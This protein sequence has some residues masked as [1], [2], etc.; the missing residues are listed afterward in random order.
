MDLLSRTVC[1]LAQMYVQN[2]WARANNLLIQVGL[3]PP[4]ECASFPSTA[5]DISGKLAVTCWVF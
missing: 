5:T 1:S 4:P 2:E 3:S